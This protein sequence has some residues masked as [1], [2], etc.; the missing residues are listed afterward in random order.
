[1]NEGNKPPLRL[2]P[3]EGPAVAAARR[4]MWARGNDVVSHSIYGLLMN[5]AEVSNMVSTLLD[6]CG[7]AG[8]TPEQSATLNSLMRATISVQSAFISVIGNPSQTDENEAPAPLL[9][10]VRN[11]AVIVES[12]ATVLETVAPDIKDCCRA[13]RLAVLQM[14]EAAGPLTPIAQTPRLI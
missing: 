13:L 7:P 10:A 1:M 2:D 8:L 14:R 6:A 3:N 12:A 9:R 11:H 5:Q 4:R